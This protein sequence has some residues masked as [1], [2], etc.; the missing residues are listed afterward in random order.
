M[1]GLARLIRVTSP[2][3]VT[4]EPRSPTMLYRTVLCNSDVRQGQG[5]FASTVPVVAPVQVASHHDV[6]VTEST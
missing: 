3:T 5:Q 2:P 4:P 1:S 6:Q